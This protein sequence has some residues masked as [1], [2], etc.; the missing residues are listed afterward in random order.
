MSSMTS[1]GG[2]RRRALNPRAAVIL[3]VLVAV[4]VMGMQRLHDRQMS[5]T[6]EFLRSTAFKSVESQDYRTAQSQLSQY[7]AMK[8]SDLGAREKLS[9]LLTEHIKTPQALEQAVRLNEELLRKEASNDEL[10]LRQARI[11][12]QLNRMADASDHLKLL[13]SA[14]PDDAEVWYLSGVAA[15]AE[16]DLPAAINCLKRSLRCPKQIPESYALL[17]KLAT[18]N[19]PVEFQPD[20]LMAQMIAACVSGKS[21]HIRADYSIERHRYAE[22]IHELWKALAETADDLVLNAKLVRCIQALASSESNRS[23]NSI[24]SSAELKKAILH[25]EAQVTELPQ[26]PLMRLHLATMLWKNRDRAKAIATLESGIQVMPRAFSLHEALIEYLVSENQATRARRILDNIPAGGLPR[27][28][29]HYCRGRI[30]MAEKRWKEAAAALEQ[31]LAF[32]RKDSGLFSRAQMSYAI[33]RSQSGESRAALEAFRS[34]VA[35]APESTGARLGIAS[36]WV[37]S[38]QIDLAISEYR[39]LRNVAGVNACLA[40]LL[41]QKNLQQPASLRTWDEVDAL[42]RE[43]EP[44]IADAA[45]RIL[46]RADRLFASGQIIA[47]IHTLEY[48]AVVQPK[49]DELRSALR[50]LTSD[51]AADLRSRLDQLAEEDPANAEV[52]SMRVRQELSKSGL[53]QGLAMIESILPLFGPSSTQ[54][55]RALLV[56]IRTLDHA[57]SQER[58]IDRKEF[59]D[60]LEQTSITYSQQLADLNPAYERELVRTLIRSGRIADALRVTTAQP[61]KGR[62]EMRAAALL[63]CVRSS[64]RRDKVIPRITRAMYDLVTRFPTNI[65]LRFCYAELMLYAREYALAEQTLAPIS[66][67]NQDGRISALRA[68]LRSAEEKNLSEAKDMIAKVVH[69]NANEAIFREVQARVLLTQ[70]EPEQALTI[71]EAIPSDELTLAGQIYVVTALLKLHRDGE[72]YTAFE[73]LQAIDETDA[74]FPADEDLRDI[75]SSQLLRPSTAL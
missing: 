71:L 58:Q 25:F 63:E 6:L 74:L 35:A 31:T 50:R 65:E 52:Q 61:E 23:E 60:L 62:P 54:R 43:D 55:E 38:G 17:A 41:I 47:A 68:W 39:Q 9:W 22:A 34:V 64:T 14:R 29:Y 57:T 27:E 70:N 36:A 15:Q 46:L 20:A 18:D 24:A 45:Q 30:L 75:I 51:Y 13:Q 66:S 56:A 40:D 4:V 21:H 49:R 33:C 26:N 59:V 72:A 1:K 67:S 11:A 19:T 73:Q 32:G 12:V 10:R 8:P 28:S 3:A 42:I 53:P 37:Q 7:V 5:S 44:Q 16:R 48:G 2:P 69:H